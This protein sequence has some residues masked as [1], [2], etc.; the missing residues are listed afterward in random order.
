VVL[1]VRGDVDLAASDRLWKEINSRLVPAA[2]VVIDCSGITF[3]DSM[4]LRALIRAAAAAD[5]VADARFALAAPTQPVSRV[6]DL[7][8]TVD[9]F[10]ILPEPPD[11]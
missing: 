10:V 8:G 1:M 2:H 11:A 4:G 9:L 5:E 7:S 6:L 3:L